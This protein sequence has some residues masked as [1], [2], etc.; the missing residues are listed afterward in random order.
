MLLR[1]SLSVQ[2]YEDYRDVLV[3][4]STY[5]MNRYGMPFIPFIGLNNHRR[6]TVF[7]CAIVADEKEETYVWLLQIFL[8]AMC[9]KRPLSVIT[10]ANSAMIRAIRSLFPDVWHRICTWHIEKNMKL[11]LSD[12]SLAD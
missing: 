8:K 3:F 1:D 10:G 11:H 4:E 2:G 5:K 6:T 9:Q 12:K 7:G